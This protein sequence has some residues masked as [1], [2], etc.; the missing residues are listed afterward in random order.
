MFVTGGPGIGKT[1]LVDSFLSRV[2]AKNGALTAQGQC[3]E[4]YGAGEAHLPILDALDGLCG[5]SNNGATELLR[6]HAPSWLVNL[7]Q[8][9]DPTER[10]GLERQTVGITRSGDSGR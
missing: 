7:P 2:Q 3:I 6:R 4:Q 1:T 10:A 5:K 9:T 8:L